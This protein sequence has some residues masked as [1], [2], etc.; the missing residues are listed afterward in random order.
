M[1]GLFALLVASA[2]A[3]CPP[4]EGTLSCASTVTG[5]LDP[6]PWVGGDPGAQNTCAVGFEGLDSALGAFGCGPNPACQQWACFPPAYSCGVPLAGTLQE[7]PEH[8]YAFTCATSGEVEIRIS[9][10]DCDL[11][12][13]VLDATCT[14]SGAGCRAGRTASYGGEESVFFNCIQ[15]NTYHVVVEGFGFTYDAWYD[16]TWLIGGPGYCYPEA[17]PNHLGAYT[18]SFVPGDPATSGCPAAPDCDVD[19][20]G[21]P[22]QGTCGGADCD[23]TSALT[24][25]GATELADGQ[26]ND[27]DGTV[28][29]GTARYDDD[30]DGVTELGGDCD[31]ADP[32][33]FPGSFELCDGVDSDCDEQIDEGTSCSDDDGDGSCE[34]GPCVEG[35]PGDCHD[36]DASIHP[37]ATEVAGN[38]VDDDCDGQVDGQDPD[39]DGDGFT[40]A[41]GD[42]APDDPSVRPGAAEVPNGDDDDCDGLV[43]EG[44][45]VTD[46]DG[47]GA[48]ELGGDCDDGDDDVGP[49]ANELENGVDDDCDGN[50]DEGTPSGDDDRDGFTERGGDCDDSDDDITPGA[51]ELLNGI[52]DDCDELVDEGLIDRDSDGVTEDEGDCDD[53]DGFANPLMNELCDRVDNNCDGEIDEGCDDDTDPVVPPPDEPACGC[54]S[55]PGSFGGLVLAG[56]FAVRRRR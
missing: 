7:G 41:G 17:A 30:G 40:A 3:V 49:S 2:L 18:L 14:V 48:S 35:Q 55:A 8:V 47:D 4:L 20:D 21:E 6:G 11:D 31:D 42:C 22:A 26:D 19:D 16:Y 29:E 27:C 25:P 44:L 12:L 32:Q 10:M 36:G 56:L 46:D 39:P 45:S 52:D 38:G 53:L 51:T 1:T 33:V 34:Q 9:G 23:D 37:G 54:A 15:G 28:D 13:F 43:D 5:Q 24:E 50:I